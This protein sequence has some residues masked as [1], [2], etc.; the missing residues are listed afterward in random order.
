MLMTINGLSNAMQLHLETKP[1]LVLPGNPLIQQAPHRPFPVGFFLK[2]HA[3]VVR[4]SLSNVGVTDADIYTSISTWIFKRGGM[5]T[6][7]PMAESL[8]C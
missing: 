4:K 1:T 7:I 5:E 2:I 3:W 6:C 8:G